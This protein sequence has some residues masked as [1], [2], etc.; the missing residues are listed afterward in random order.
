MK[1]LINLVLI[2]F[3]TL[4]LTSCSSTKNSVKK[5][6]KF[7]W[8][9]KSFVY[10]EHYLYK[11]SCTPIN[12]N[13]FTSECYEKLLGAK[14]SGA[15]VGKTNTG[16]YV[17]TAG[18]VCD[19]PEVDLNS[20][21]PLL[22]PEFYSTDGRQKRVFYVYDF[23]AYKYQAEIITYDSVKDL[24]LMYV[25]GLFEKPLKISKKG[26]RH[27]D[28]VYNMAAPGGQFQKRTFPLFEGF[29]SGNFHHPKFSLKAMYTVPVMPGSSG[30]PIL[31]E[32]GALIGII[33]AGNVRFHH[34]MLG[35]LYKETVNF[36][37]SNNKRDLI[38]REGVSTKKAFNF[39]FD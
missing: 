12:P 26:P 19:K 14:A 5:R 2:F 39:K 21:L 7:K 3:L 33:S 1:A 6:K 29:Y 23:D 13:D 4:S 17:V 34:I 25:W 11:F 10:I 8:P 20:P 24:C 18:H 15:V 16:S 22:F 32:R 30:S 31:N 38:L 35:T 28:R 27:G 9:L 37:V 36:I